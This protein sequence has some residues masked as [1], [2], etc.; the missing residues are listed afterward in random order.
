MVGIVVCRLDIGCFVGEGLGFE[1]AI[2]PM[3]VLLRRASGEF[4]LLDAGAIR[5]S[6]STK[7]FF[8]H[9]SGSGSSLVCDFSS[10]ERFAILAEAKS[11]HSSSSAET[12]PGVM[13]A[14][15]W[16][17]SVVPAGKFG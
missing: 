13:T 12:V 4:L 11:P 2:A 8:F 1:L 14:V 16:K 17:K 5:L 3:G 15:G 10:T 9:G 6:K 7:F